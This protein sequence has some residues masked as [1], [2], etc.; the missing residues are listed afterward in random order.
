MEG[1]RRGVREGRAEAQCKHRALL[2]FLTQE[3]R[4]LS[5]PHTHY[6]TFGTENDIF[7]RPPP[8]VTF[9][10]VVMSTSHGGG[11]ALD[12]K[13]VSVFV[14]VYSGRGLI[15]HSA[16]GGG[17]AQRDGLALVHCGIW[18]MQTSSHGWVSH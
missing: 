12:V 7:P 18:A 2:R 5:P 11:G 3:L 10:T 6:P 8:P 17:A 16:R 14:C 9:L 4:D 15:H 1:S 13:G